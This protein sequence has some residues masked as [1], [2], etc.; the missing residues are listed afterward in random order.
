[1]S[2]PADLRIKPA[3][4][5]DIAVMAAVHADALADPGVTGPAWDVAGFAELMAMPGAF[6][7]IALDPAD[8]PLG[9]VLARAVAGEAEILT[10]GVRPAMRGRGV[11]QALMRAAA[12]E[13]V[14]QGAQDLFLEVAVTNGPARALYARLGMEEAGRRR[15][16][17]QMPS[18]PVDA[19]IMRAALPLPG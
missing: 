10:L 16:Y 17:Y 15:A 9:L 11:A 12:A 19:V 4:A 6:G 7:L 8:E 1:M 14:R 13:A 3:G 5:L 2:A 18:G